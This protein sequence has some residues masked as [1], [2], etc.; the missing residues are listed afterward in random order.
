MRSGP[1]E[2][3]RPTARGLT[4]ATAFQKG[5]G[6]IHALSHPVGALYDTHHGLLNGIVM[7][8]VVK[9]NRKK[10]EKDIVRAAAYLGI[11]G[12]FNGFLKW[13][14]ALRKEIGIG[15]AGINR[16]GCAVRRAALLR[17]YLAECFGLLP[18][19]QGDRRKPHQT[20]I[21]RTH[22]INGT[23]YRVTTCFEPPQGAAHGDANI[24]AAARRRVFSLLT[25]AHKPLHEIGLV[26]SAAGNE[27]I[28]ERQ[29]H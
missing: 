16:L 14:L 28:S 18:I 19:A 8:Y 7:P 3:F 13:I 2:Q 15:N 20:A 11:K 6:A 25:P 9:A 10:I 23:C 21:A 27:G 4:W 5:L 29:S 1:S 22:R 26:K 12:G 17:G 24:E